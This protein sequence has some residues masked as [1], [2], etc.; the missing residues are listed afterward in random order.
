M[1]TLLT[2]T[3]EVTT[4]EDM[5]SSTATRELPD[6]Y[7]GAGLDRREKIVLQSEPLTS[8]ASNSRVPRGS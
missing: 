7:Q 8:T 5:D 6:S 1:E 2:W 4:V 3:R